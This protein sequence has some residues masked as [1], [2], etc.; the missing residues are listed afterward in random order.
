MSK[1][2]RDDRYTGQL[3]KGVRVIELSTYLAAPTAGRVLSEWGAEVIKVETLKGDVYRGHGPTM[4]MPITPFANP[5]F[6]MHNSG[7][8]FTGLNLRSEKGMECLHRLL[9]TA[10]VFVTN[11]RLQA[12]QQ[13]H[14]T[15]EELHEKY[16]RLI[17]AHVLGYGDEG[18][19]ANKP[20]FDFTAFWAR[21]GLMRDIAPKDGPPVNGIVGAGDL[22]VSMGIL[23]GVCAS[24]YKRQATGVGEKVSTSLLQMATWI[25]MSTLSSV[26]FGRQLPRS[27]SDPNQA[28][29][30]CYE[31]RDGEWLWVGC[32]DYNLFPKLVTIVL[33]RPDYL[34]DPRCVPRTSYL[35][36]ADELTAEFDVIFKT[37]DREE[38]VQRLIKADIAH[39]KIQHFKDIET[40]PQVL[41][42]NYLF[43]HEYPDGTKAVFCP[44]PVHFDSIDHWKYDIR[45]AGPVGADNNRCLREVG[46]SEEEILQMR[47]AG[48]IV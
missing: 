33:E 12:L 25:N 4:Q 31:C 43:E 20:G 29:N 17:Y 13:M 35:Q 42:N 6:D 40:D 8:S 27:R 2:N 18:P 16:P 45:P 1:E 10:D 34:E 32:L 11:N 30:N 48:D 28:A 24:L 7:K 22:V 36:H 38:W 19:L 21:S 14:L 39:E 15:W 37:R 23:A 47:A 26:H 9:A 44:P 3:L 41:A 46:Y 5:N